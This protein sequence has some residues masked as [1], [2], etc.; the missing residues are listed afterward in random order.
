MLQSGICTARR[1]QRQRGC[2][3]VKTGRWI[4]SLDGLTGLQL[5]GLR[6]GY[7]SGESG[8]AGS[9]ALERQPKASSYSVGILDVEGVSHFERG[10]LPFWSEHGP[11]LAVN[12]FIRN[13]DN[14]HEKH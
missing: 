11:S 4:G 6:W 13:R 8:W 2:L 3:G 14:Y 12:H 5:R 7:F 9:C 10:E 1:L